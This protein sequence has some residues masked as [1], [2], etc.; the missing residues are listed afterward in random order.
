MTTEV[1]GMTEEMMLQDETT[2]EQQVDEAETVEEAVEQE[3]GQEVVE[4][5]KVEEPKVETKQVDKEKHWRD[6]ATQANG[7]LAILARGYKK[8]IED[9]VVT[10]EEV[11]SEIGT[12][13]KTIQNIIEGKGTPYDVKVR[14]FNEKLNAIKGLAVKQYGSLDAL[15]ERVQ[16]YDWLVKNDA[17]AMEQFMS[18]G[19]DSLLDG[20]FGV[21]DEV[22]EDYRAAQNPRALRQRMKEL[23]AQ[24]E[25]KKQE[26]PASQP[27]AKQP[28]TGGLSVA[29]KP[30]ESNDR[31]GKV[32]G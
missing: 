17:A 10:Y 21:D 16:A 2:L 9:G 19:A 12:D 24:F 4:G 8:L 23:E 14:Q 15:N 30:Q 26:A 5:E 6:A 27:K 1:E 25:G 18:S 7:Q 32:F 13:P 11:A 28:L 3:E 31:F 29:P 22:L 20:L